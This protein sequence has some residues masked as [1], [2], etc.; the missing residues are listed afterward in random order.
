MLPGCFASIWD[1]MC[2][3]T[4]NVQISSI[5]SFLI[6]ANRTFELLLSQQ[7]KSECILLAQFNFY[8]VVFF[9]NFT[10]ATNWI[11]R[12]F[13]IVIL[14]DNFFLQWYAFAN[15][16]SCWCGMLIRLDSFG[17]VIVWLFLP[18]KWWKHKNFI[19]SFVK[20]RIFVRF[21]DKF[22]FTVR[23]IPQCYEYSLIFTKC[24]CNAQLKNEFTF[25]I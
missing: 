6:I 20:W 24:L 15:C 22:H 8:F 10:K 5:S 21:S 16:S 7:E 17:I 2:D 9:Y 12:L 1:L 4:R 18:W 3:S 25:G 13:A 14:S 23:S 19:H 11:F